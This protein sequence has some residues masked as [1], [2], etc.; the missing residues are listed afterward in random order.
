MRL[1]KLSRTTF[2]SKS[3]GELISY[4]NDNRKVLRSDPLQHYK[5]KKRTKNQ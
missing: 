2:P 1:E 4:K 5:R 3:S